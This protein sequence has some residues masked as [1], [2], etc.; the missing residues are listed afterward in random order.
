M[1]WAALFL[2]S[3]EKPDEYYIPNFKFKEF[4]SLA[5]QKGFTLPE[6]NKL[7]KI[8]NIDQNPIKWK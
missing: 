5:L 7:L 1:D 2:F 4:E 6:F 8:R 3:V